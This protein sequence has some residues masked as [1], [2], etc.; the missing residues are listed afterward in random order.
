MKMSFQGGSGRGMAGEL[1][2]VN[3]AVQQ[4]EFANCIVEHNLEDESGTALDFKNPSH[5][6]MLDPRIGDEINRHIDKLNQFD[7]DEDSGKGNS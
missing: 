2:M 4:Y 3:A 1:Q 5:V 7:D 6:A